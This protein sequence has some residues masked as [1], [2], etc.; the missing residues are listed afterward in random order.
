MKTINLQYD[1][2]DLK[3]TLVVNPGE[4]VNLTTV[5]RYTKPH[6][7][8]EVEVRAVVMGDGY[9]KLKG[10]IIIEKGA[11]LVEGFLRQKVLLVGENARAEAIPELEIE[12]NEVK[13]SHAA[14]VGRIDEEQ[15]FYLMSRGLS[16]KEAEKL[17][18]EAFLS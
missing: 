17:I 2:R 9:L 15:I 12:C 6:Q 8:G 10:T 3:K 16:K 11:E 13:A 5:S 1:G 7:T 18:I 4:S 14:S